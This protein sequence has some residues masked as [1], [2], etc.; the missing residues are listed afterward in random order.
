MG[1]FLEEQADLG[2]SSTFKSWDTIRVTM[3]NKRWNSNQIHMPVVGATLV[4]ALV[5]TQ[6]GHKTRPYRELPRGV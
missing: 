2:K 5:P 6:G 4:V 1:G 3:C